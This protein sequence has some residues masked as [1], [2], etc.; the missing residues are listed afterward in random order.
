MKSINNKALESRKNTMESSKKITQ[1]YK[2]FTAPLEVR[3]KRSMLGSSWRN[4]NTRI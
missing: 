2:V 1:D 4:S 3:K